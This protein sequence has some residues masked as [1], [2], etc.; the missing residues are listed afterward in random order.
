MNN[1]LKT[2][3]NKEYDSKINSDG[4]IDI[5]YSQQIIDPSMVVL[6]LL[7]SLFFSSCSGI[8]AV[9][10]TFGI[11]GGIIT[12]IVLIIALFIAGYIGVG[13]VNNKKANLKIIPGQGVEF[14][15][16]SLVKSE[17][18]KIGLQSG[19]IGAHCFK[20]YALA[21]SEKIYVTEYVSASVAKA[22]QRILQES[23]SKA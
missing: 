2:A 4:T 20:V 14:G 9:D 11:P 12:S 18:D 13:L 23:L 8:F 5:T 15:S 3:F 19:S 7:P 22:I 17:V 10:N 21:G 1:S 6:F 16:H